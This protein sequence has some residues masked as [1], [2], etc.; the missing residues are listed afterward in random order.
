MSRL[1]CLVQF[2][3]LFVTQR[4]AFGERGSRDNCLHMLPLKQSEQR[5][6]Q[7]AGCQFHPTEMIIYG[8]TRKPFKLVDWNVCGMSTFSLVLFLRERK[9]VEFKTYLDKFRG[10]KEEG[11]K[12][13]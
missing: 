5:A 6:D 8:D 13:Y 11:E 3:P 4:Y 9:G 1:L 10:E 7:S 2:W 12:A